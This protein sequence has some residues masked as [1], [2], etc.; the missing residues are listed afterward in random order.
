MGKQTPPKPIALFDMDGTGA[1][2]NG[3]MERDLRKMMGPGEPELLAH[4]DEEKYPHIKFRRT[5]IKSQPEWWFNLEPIPR[6]FRVLEMLRELGFRITVLT[7]GPKLTPNA[8]T[9]KMR[10]CQKYINDA[11]VTVTTDE[12][13]RV[14]GRVLVDDWVPYIEPW[15]KRRPRGLVV[16]PDQP[17]NQGFSHPQVVRHTENDEEVRKLLIEQRDRPLLPRDDDDEG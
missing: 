15:L 10:W 17:W 16:L 14:Y 13:A 5:L 1:N 11:K 2:F 4:E 12:K 7:R 6:G 3:A 9:E 8:W